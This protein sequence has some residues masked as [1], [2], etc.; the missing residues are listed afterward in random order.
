[1]N[2]MVYFKIIFTN[3]HY[4][5]IVSHRPSWERNVWGLYPSVRDFVSLCRNVHCNPIG[6]EYSLAHAKIVDMTMPKQLHVIMDYLPICIL[7]MPVSLYMAVDNH[8]L[9]PSMQPS[10]C[11]RYRAQPYDPTV[12]WALAS[13]ILHA[14]KK[15]RECPFHQTATLN[16]YTTHVVLVRQIFN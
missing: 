10:L 16:I 4:E 3:S 13:T 5:Y 11:T 12:A 15:L 2:N 1:M 14:R 6:Q 7:E 8:H 9:A